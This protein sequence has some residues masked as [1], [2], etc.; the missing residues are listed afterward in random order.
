MLYVSAERCDGCGACLEVCSPGAIRL[1]GGKA[2]IDQDR[3]TQCGECI[4]ACPQG[5]ISWTRVVA[6]DE[7]WPVPRPEPG[8]IHI[9]QP[10]RSAPK[11]RWLAVTGATLSFLGREIVPRAV[12]WL[13]DTWDRRQVQDRDV[14]AARTNTTPTSPT[15]GNTTVSRQNPTP[16]GARGFRHRHGRGGRT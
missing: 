2:I 10:A 11:G 5:A 14:S 3:C 13:L 15:S 9:V 4:E 6:N 1:E 16:S 8:V 7:I 12:N